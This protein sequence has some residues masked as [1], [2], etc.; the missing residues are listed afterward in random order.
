MDDSTIDNAMDKLAEMN[1]RI[2]YPGFI[3]ND[4]KIMEGYKE[5]IK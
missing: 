5:V 3:D 1:H 4:S 2:A